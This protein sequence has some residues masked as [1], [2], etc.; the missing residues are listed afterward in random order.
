VAL[1]Q[2][3]PFQLVPADITGLGYEG[4]AL[5]FAV[6][7]VLIAGGFLPKRFARGQ[8]HFHLHTDAR[9]YGGNPLDKPPNHS[10]LAFSR[11]SASA[12][13]AAFAVGAARLTSDQ[14][15]A[16]TFQDFDFMNG[17]RSAALMR[18]KDVRRTNNHR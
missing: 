3:E 6:G 15:R 13:L 8:E 18:N 4:G 2:P 11:F 10:G 5:V 14:C 12:I 7:L 16:C 9:C 17:A 1:G